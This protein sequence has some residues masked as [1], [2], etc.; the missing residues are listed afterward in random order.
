MIDILTLKR[1]LDYNPNTG[2]L[3]WIN[4]TT[5]RD[6][7]GQRAGSIFVSKDSRRYWRTKLLGH[8]YFNHRLAF[9]YMT[10]EWPEQIDHK[11]DNGLNNRWN[12]LRDVDQSQNFANRGTL[13]MRGVDQVSPNGYRAKVSYYSQQIYLGVFPT[14]EQAF[15]A[16]KN[17]LIEL[18]G[19][20]TIY[21]R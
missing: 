17:K 7:I 18:H 10:G 19:D 20:Y 14:K 3:I 12:N 6:M 8:N 5:C 21:R 11:D 9:F 15:E 13:D 16:Y 1:Y 2:D 4:N